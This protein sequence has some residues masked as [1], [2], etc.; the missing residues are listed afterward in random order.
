MVSSE[1][2][3]HLFL[4]IFLLLSDMYVLIYICHRKMKT[5]KTYIILWVNKSEW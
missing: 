2:S 4:K 3:I 5:L 1:M